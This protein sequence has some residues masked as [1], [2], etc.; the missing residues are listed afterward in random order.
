MRGEGAHLEVKH[1]KRQVQLTVAV[2]LGWRRQNP[3]AHNVPGIFFKKKYLG[4]KMYNHF[5]LLKKTVL[6]TRENPTAPIH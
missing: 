3:H 6:C 4:N 2:R 1:A 5:F